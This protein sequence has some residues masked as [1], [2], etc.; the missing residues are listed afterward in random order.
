MAPIN[1]LQDKKC[2]TV[3]IENRRNAIFTSLLCL[4]SPVNELPE[5]QSDDPDAK[6]EGHK[7]RC[8]GKCSTVEEFWKE[9]KKT[10]KPSQLQYTEAYYLMREPFDPQW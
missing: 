1:D 9:F 10:E 3:R 5:K 2:H 4:P 8:L 6:H 7:I